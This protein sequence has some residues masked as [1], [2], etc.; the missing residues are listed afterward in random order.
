MKTKAAFLVLLAGMLWGIIGL[1]VRQL[2]ILSFSS[3]DIVGIRAVTTSF[4]LFVFLLVYDRKLLYFRLKDIW[5]F[6]G[7]GIH[8]IIY[9]NFCYFKAI[10]LTSLSVAAILLYTAPA[11]VML[12]SALLFRER[13]TKTKVISL[14]LTFIGCVFVTGVISGNH[15]LNIYGILAGLG[16]G[17]GYAL[18]SI[19]SRYALEKGYHSLTISFYTFVFAMSGTIPFV[20]YSGIFGTF[21]QDFN[22]VLFCLVFGLV[23]TVLPYFLYTKGLQEL[24]NSKAS[25]IASIEPVTAALIGSAAFHEKL[26]MFELAGVILVIGAIILNNMA[27]QSQKNA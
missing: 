23:S 18:Y 16:S 9:F 10:T 21:R 1:F 27:P 3:L 24:E 12:L 8:S 22:I 7:T 20:N 6:F 4:I 17:F 11:I 2:N 13:I 25:I 5:L 15:N 19:F 14:I 26:S